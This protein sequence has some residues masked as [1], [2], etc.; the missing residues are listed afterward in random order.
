MLRH[1]FVVCTL[2][3]LG[4]G[5]GGDDPPKQA[6]T[7]AAPPA[8]APAPITTAT[9]VEPTPPPKPASER[10]SIQAQMSAIRAQAD[11][12]A[13]VGRM[14][15]ERGAAH[16]RTVALYDQCVRHLATGNIQGADASFRADDELMKQGRP[17]FE[18]LRV[19][20]AET[21]PGLQRQL[22]AINQRD[23]ERRLKDDPEYRAQI[24][25]E[26]Q[27]QEE[28]KRAAAERV[29]LEEA[30]RE[31][32]HLETI[33]AME[34]VA[35]GVPMPEGHPL[36]P[37]IAW[38]DETLQLFEEQKNAPEHKRRDWSA[39]L[40]FNAERTKQSLTITSSGETTWALP[41]ERWRMEYSHHEQRYTALQQPLGLTWMP[42]ELSPPVGWDARLLD[43]ILQRKEEIEGL[44]GGPA[45]E[46]RRAGILLVQHAPSAD[47]V[48]GAHV[49][50]AIQTS[51]HRVLS[52]LYLSLLFSKADNDRVATIKPSLKTG[53]IVLTIKADYGFSPEGV[54]GSN[55]TIEARDATVVACDHVDHKGRTTTLV[56]RP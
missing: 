16:P 39:T 54:L 51:P 22:D 29:R 15:L 20:Y 55:A 10:E 27:K 6:Q 48:N 38:H 9:P 52:R 26:R 14:T 1:S 24:E 3:A 30:E 5:C 23:H 36:R 13:K 42:L 21:I 33:A 4:T 44:S 49:Y 31:R 17:A 11:Q 7:P 46:G 41:A 19:L 53:F 28:A 2:A 34:Q 56:A 8:P 32:K 12:L 47:L 50:R 43:R 37:L 40:A 25:A 18:A 35:A 45:M